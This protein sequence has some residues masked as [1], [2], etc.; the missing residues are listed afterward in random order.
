MPSRGRGLCQRTR[1]GRAL[2]S[3]TR[4]GRG[5]P[6]RPRSCVTQLYPVLSSQPPA[7][8]ATTQRCSWRSAPATS[9]SARGS[10]L[11]DVG[12]EPHLGLGEP[13]GPGTKLSG[14]GRRL[15]T[16]L[17]LVPAPCCRRA[18]HQSDSSPREGTC[19]YPRQGEGLRELVFKVTAGLFPFA[20]GVTAQEASPQ[21]PPSAGSHGGTAVGAGGLGGAQAEVRDSAAGCDIGTDLL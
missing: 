4:L 15:L 2:C 6:A 10:H 14:C 1:P 11:G 21:S 17:G 7:A 3:R 16:T 19:L 9:V 8:L 18:V 20:H 12:R 5:L 13:S